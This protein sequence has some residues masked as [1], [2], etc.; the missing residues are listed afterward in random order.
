[1]VRRESTSNMKTSPSSLPVLQ[2]PSASPLVL[3]QCKTTA[4]CTEAMPDLAKICSCAH[5]WFSSSSRPSIFLQAGADGRR[6]VP[7]K[8]LPEQD[9]FHF[10][11]EGTCNMPIRAVNR[12]GLSNRMVSSASEELLQRLNSSLSNVSVSA[13]AGAPFIVCAPSPPRYN[14]PRR[15]R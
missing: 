15:L 6:G 5:R 9:T 14:T 4:I 10:L 3:N 8:H 13:S 1:M 12:R 11:Q 2:C 7:R